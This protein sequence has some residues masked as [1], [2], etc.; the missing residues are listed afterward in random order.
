MKALPMGA[1][2]TSLASPTNRQAGL[3]LLKNASGG[4]LACD[5]ERLKNMP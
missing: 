3:L 2:R 5:A 4:G 1:A